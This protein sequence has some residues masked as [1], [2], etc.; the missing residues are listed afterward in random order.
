MRKSKIAYLLMVLVL[1][2]G[3]LTACGSEEKD[4]KTGENVQTSQQ[5]DT[6]KTQPD[7]EAEVKSEDKTQEKAE[8]VTDTPDAQTTEQTETQPAEPVEIID[9]MRV[10]TG[11]SDGYTK[12]NCVYTI[13]KGGEYSF[14]GTLSEG[15]IVVDAPEEEV[16]LSLENVT[17]SSTSD[18]V[19]FVENA[20]KCTV[21]AAENSINTL[22]D[23]R[24]KKVSEDETDAGS[25]CIYSKDDLKLSGK[26]KLIIN[27]TY[28]NGIHSKNDVKIKNIT[29]EVT[30]PNNGIKGNDSI[31]V[32]SGNITITSTE[33]D[34]MKTKDTDLSSKGKQRGIISIESGV[35]TVNAADDCFDAAYELQQG[36]DA[37][38]SMNEE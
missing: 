30:A 11:V 10:I 5:E 24:A 25:A 3:I 29:L 32:E 34:G 13:I 22:N 16:V 21:K 8:T 20:E 4:N 17:I 33:G 19:I 15:R 27:A 2:T 7:K 1:V 35:V 31:T 38:I 26:G 28:N 37:V 9:T 14:T 23:N 36:P 6:Q 12:E 18:S